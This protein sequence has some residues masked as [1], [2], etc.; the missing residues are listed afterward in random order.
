MASKN[1]S[2]ETPR[3]SPTLSRCLLS[4]GPPRPLEKAGRLTFLASHNYD[5][6]FCDFP[7]AKLGELHGNKQPPLQVPQNNQRQAAQT[8]KLAAAAHL[9]DLRQAAAWRRRQRA[10]SV[11]AGRAL[12]TA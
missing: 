3:P 4:A 8:L 6:L 10:G 11:Y 7:K 9:N 12:A 1:K 5:D 2:A